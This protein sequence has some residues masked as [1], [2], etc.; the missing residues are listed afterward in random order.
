[1][2]AAIAALFIVGWAPSV[3]AHPAGLPGANGTLWVTNANTNDVT[4]FDAATGDVIATIPVGLKPIGV[5][6]PS[7][8]GKVYVS[9]EVSNT[10]SVISTSTWTVL[11][12]IPTGPKPH[13]IGH[14]PDG[15]IVYVAEFGTNKVGVI[16]TMTDTLVAEFAAGPSTDLSHALWAPTNGG[17]LYVVNSGGNRLV[18]LNSDTGLTQWTLAVGSG[19]SDILTSHNGKLGYLSVTGES[20]VKV[21]DLETASVVSEV[22][23]GSKPRTLWLS[24]NDRWLVASL[25]E[26][27]QIAVVD[28]RDAT[29]TTVAL[30]APP[31]HNAMSENGRYSFVVVEGSSPGVTVVDMTT[32]RVVDHYPYPGG[33]APHGIWYVPARMG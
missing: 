15:R 21:V 24:P 1:M 11:T 10:V 6:A 4:A 8:L 18:A 17:S 23:V 29:V 16:D 22:A 20:K 27:L 19:P 28:L 14:S 5:I 13:H 25:R 30:G 31:N 12:T 3:A 7:G 33:G 2:V 9:N 26:S 32:L